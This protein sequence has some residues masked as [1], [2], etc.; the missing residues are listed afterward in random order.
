MRIIKAEKI[1]DIV[2]ELCLEANFSLRKDVL[3]A[4]KHAAKTEKNKRAKDVLR[5]LVKNA[6]IAR[7]DK[8]AICQDTGMAVV[9]VDLGQDVKIKGS[10]EKAINDGVRQAYAKGYLRKSIVN[11]PILRKNTKDNTPAIIH[12]KI[13]PGNK[14]KISVLAKGFGS[15]NVSK[16]KMLKPTDG[17][18]EI[19]SFVADSVKEAGPDACP[20]FIVGVGVGGTLD[21]AITLAKEALFIPLDARN[22]QKHLAK[23][24]KDIFAKVKKL[25]M[26]PMGFGGKYTALGVK[27]LAHP[28]HIAG[29][30]VA[31]NISCHAL[32]TAEKNI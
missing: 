7:N 27:V 4:L 21:K 19:I 8:I 32:R 1:R 3:A 25:C 13:V 12:Y 31:V 28:T 2:K 24:E 22:R 17:A 23:L 18:S 11:D 14:I 16:T 9:F 30:P 20:P 26:G 15:E 5:I 6:E 10:L 29:L